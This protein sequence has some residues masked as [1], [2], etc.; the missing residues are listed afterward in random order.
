M[1]KNVDPTGPHWVTSLTLYGMLKQNSAFSSI[2][3][4]GDDSVHELSQQCIKRSAYQIKVNKFPCAIGLFF[5]T[6]DFNGEFL[7]AASIHKHLCFGSRQEGGY[8]APK[9]LIFYLL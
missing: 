7:C 5:T 9:S 6:E 4:T 8:Y 2:F 1:H 3:V